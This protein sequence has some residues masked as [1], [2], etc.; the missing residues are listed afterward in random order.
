M[1]GNDN[2]SSNV[3]T[4][5]SNN[6]LSPEQIELIAL[7]AQ[8]AAMTAKASAK[9]VKPKPPTYDGTKGTLRGFLTKLRSYHLFYAHKL[10]AESDKVLNASN[11]LADNAMD[12]FEPTLRDYLDNIGQPDKMDSKTQAIFQSY[13]KF[14]ESLKATFGDPDEEQS[15]ERKIRNLRQRGSAS[16]YVAQ[17]QQIIPALEWEDEPLMAQF[18]EGL[19]DEVKDE[20]V[21]EDRPDEFSK[22]AAMAV[23]ID[24]RLYERRMEK[25]G[26][27]SNHH[28]KNN[29]GRYQANT[30]Q[31]RS[32]PNTQYRGQASTQYGST[33]H[34]GPMELDA[35]QRRPPPKCYNCNKLGHFARDCGQK[36]VRW[37]RVPERRPAGQ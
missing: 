9:A 35:T 34:P 10:P 22:Y 2:T 1:A 19:K 21:K 17:F 25:R 37:E 32:Q 30:P 7:R 15:A 24:N 26:G 5:R 14:E 29:R 6:E 33:R 13:A 28:W 20:L 3:G 18:Y 12:W 31:P 11:C 8:I 36:K 16:D 23:R 27:S 4:S